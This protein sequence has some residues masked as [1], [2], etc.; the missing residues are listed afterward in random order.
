MIGRTHRS[1]A[2]D[3]SRGREWSAETNDGSLEDRDQG[4]F[5]RPAT[6]R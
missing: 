1:D 2:I 3:F 6:A 5:W 4:A